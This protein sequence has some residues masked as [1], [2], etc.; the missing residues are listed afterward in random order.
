[1]VKGENVERN[2]YIHNTIVA[3]C[4]CYHLHHILLPVM[5]PQPTLISIPSPFN[6]YF[7]LIIDVIIIL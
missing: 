2:L 3:P 6:F 5:Y 1:M 7:Y 4:H